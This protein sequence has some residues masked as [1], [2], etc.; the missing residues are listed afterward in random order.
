MA[1]IGS[2]EIPPVE[3]TVSR[4]A[5]GAQHAQAR[6]LVEVEL[7]GRGL[8]RL[9]GVELGAGRGARGQAHEVAAREDHAV[10]AGDVDRRVALED[11]QVLVDLPA[12]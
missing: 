4:A 5:L 3:R 8:D 11:L 7:V 12:R 2:A 1:G 10:A 9:D 6:R